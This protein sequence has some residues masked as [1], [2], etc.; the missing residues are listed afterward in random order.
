MSSQQ[1]IVIL[2][3][4]IPTLNRKD[5]LQ[6]TLDH[7]IEQLDQS[8][9]SIELIVSDNASDDGTYTLFDSGSKYNDVVHYTYFEKRVDI[10]KS[11]ERSV[12]LCNGDFIIIFGDDDIPL[13][14]YIHEITKELLNNRD[15]AFLYV[16]RIIG[17]SKLENSSEIPHPNKPFGSQ[18]MSASDFICR[19]THWP[20]FITCLVFSKK[21]W[22]RGSI[23]PNIFPGFNFLN[24]VYAGSKDCNVCFIAS[25]LVLQRR[26]IQSWK[27][28]WPQYWLISIPEILINLEK[29]ESTIGAL[30][31]W[32]LKE[33]TNK[34]YF[35]DCFVAKAYNYS[36]SS[37]F[38]ELSRQYQKSNLRKLIS[39]FVQYFIP[40]NIAKFFYSKTGKMT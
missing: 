5:L 19:F 39:F 11:F 29:N 4:V 32:Q 33:V 21:S 3:I 13:P 17:D 28:N 37:S 38:W 18:S 30:T 2:S 24:K 23:E 34:K 12:D 31:N 9:V 6:I 25:P 26:G 16:N 1:D 10:D 14:G 22:T 7:L 40:V 15:A 36:N 8:K 20:G 27:S 35:I